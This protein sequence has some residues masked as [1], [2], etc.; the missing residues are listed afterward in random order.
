MKTREAP[1]VLILGDRVG[2]GEALRKRLD[3]MGASAAA[4]TGH[5]NELAETLRGSEWTAVVVLTHDDPLALR[6]TLL[7]AHVRPDLPLWVTMFDRTIVHRFREILPSVN[8]VAGAELVASALA[9]HCE[10][11]IR[12]HGRE[13]GRR[14]GGMRIVDDA[15]RLLLYAGAGLLIAQV[16]QT[17]TTMIAMHDDFV[18]ALYF[19]T[20]AL[21]TVTDVPRSETSPVWFKLFSTAATMVSVALLAIFTAA[22]VRRLG[23]PRLTT[24][25]GRRQPAAANHAL[26]VGFGQ[27]GFRLALQLQSRGMRVVALERDIDAPNV[28][29]ARRAGIPVAIGRGDDRATLELLGVNRCAVLAAVTSDDLT[30]VAIGLAA[31]GVRPEISLVM[32][33]GDGNVADETASL[34]HLGRICDAHELIAAEIATSI[35]EQG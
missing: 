26:L 15:L 33:L 5:D 31:T 19:S 10:E 25:F 13:P 17:A 34:L 27:I 6:L 20:R 18:D 32:R 4:V 22:L 7:S 3:G 24:L 23:R 12:Q 14:R 29:L 9:D 30:N 8:V 16:L 11:V 21:A 1:R 2:M 28:R 35:C